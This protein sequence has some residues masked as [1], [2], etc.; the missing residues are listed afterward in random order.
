MLYFA[1]IVTE[2]AASS[3]FAFN[4]TVPLFF[5]SSFIVSVNIVTAL[6]VA[7]ESSFIA[8]VIS[9]FSSSFSAIVTTIASSSATF[10]I[11]ISVF[12]IFPVSLFV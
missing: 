10:I 1:V 9:T 3:I 2:D 12:T 6:L 4:V 8:N 11:A 7:I 5:P